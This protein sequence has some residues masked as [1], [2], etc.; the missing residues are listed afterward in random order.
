MPKVSVIT[1]EKVSMAFPQ[2]FDWVCE[3]HIHDYPPFTGE[4][5]GMSQALMSRHIKQR[6]FWWMVVLFCVT[7]GTAMVVLV[8][9]EYLQVPTASSTTIKLV[10]IYEQ[11]TKI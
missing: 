3:C 1:L 5:H 11:Y 10:S 4:I 8:I 6:L 7:C 9:R 2:K